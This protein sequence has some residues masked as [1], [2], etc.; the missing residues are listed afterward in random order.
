MPTRLHEQLH[1][2]LNP[3]YEHQLVRMGLEDGWGHPGGEWGEGDSSGG[4]KPERQGPGAWPTLAIEA[5]DSE[6]LNQLRRD[7]EWWFN[8]SNHAVKIVILARF[9]HRRRE[10]QLEK[11]EEEPRAARPGAIT[12][13]SAGTLAPV[14]WQSISITQNTTNPPSYNVAKGALVLGFKLL[15]LRGPGPG[16]GDF[17]FNI[18]DLQV[19]AAD[20]WAQLRD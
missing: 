20:I 13:R 9:D 10:I 6:S 12:T 1:L 8:T 17:V 15:F 14:L 4:P 16:G 2:A 7:M 3:R 19:Y 18:P 11:W 5:G